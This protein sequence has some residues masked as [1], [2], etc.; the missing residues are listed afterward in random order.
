[1]S[2]QK[3][4]VQAYIIT[5]HEGIH[6]S[7]EQLIQNLKSFDSMQIEIVHRTKDPISG[8][9]G[10]FLSHQFV[11]QKI[12]DNNLD[13]A[14]I[15]EE[16]AKLISHREILFSD[17]YNF[18]ETQKDWDIV[19][20]SSSF[21]YEDIKHQVNTHIFQVKSFGETLAYFVSKQGAQNIVDFKFTN[22]AYDSEFSLHPNMNLFVFRPSIFQPSFMYPSNVSWHPDIKYWLTK[23]GFGFLVQQE[24]IF[25]EKYNVKSGS[26]VVG[27]VFL[28]FLFG[29]LAF[30][31]AKK[32]KR[33]LLSE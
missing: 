4:M 25:S 7:V 24:R 20:L 30:A 9:R 18:I 16:D 6:S 27:I 23:Y 13:Y 8:T 31:L 29:L 10:C 5:I 33:H 15:F 21:R 28:S 11:C 12:L 14:I 22:V 32:A 17:V 26:I 3:N 1:M 19:S 2:Q